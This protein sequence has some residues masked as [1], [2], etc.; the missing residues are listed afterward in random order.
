MNTV[1]MF[2]GY[3]E[4]DK[5]VPKGLPEACNLTVRVEGIGTPVPWTQYREGRV[6][7]QKG[8]AKLATV[9]AMKN[10]MVPHVKDTI[11]EQVIDTLEWPI[12]ANFK[13]TYQVKAW[14]CG[15]ERYEKF[16]PDLEELQTF[17]AAQREWTLAEDNYFEINLIE[18]WDW[19]PE[20]VSETQLKEL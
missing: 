1:A 11:F 9:D 14:P 20:V 10:F 12:D 2:D 5:L 3:Y 19:G 6:W 15:W 4:A 17:I 13:L 8:V 7:V 16:F 18:H